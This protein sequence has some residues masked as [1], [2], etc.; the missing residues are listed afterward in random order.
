MLLKSY[1]WINTDTTWDEQKTTDETGRGKTEERGIST[2][3]N[4]E[5]EEKKRVGSEYPYNHI[6]ET[7]SGH[8]KEYDDT[9]RFRTSY[10]IS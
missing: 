2:E 5:R 10:G 3:T 1:H 6:R 4:E 8:I 7:E 9:I